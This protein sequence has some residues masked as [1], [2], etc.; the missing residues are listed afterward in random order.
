LREDGRV[1][2]LGFERKSV[3]AIDPK[4]QVR[5]EM[6][7]TVDAD[8]AVERSTSFLDAVGRSGSGAIT[9]KAWVENTR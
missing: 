1:V 8:G 3:P 4:V 5:D 2:V 7:L 9:A 6:L